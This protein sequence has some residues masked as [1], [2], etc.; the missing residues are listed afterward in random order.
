MLITTATQ[1]EFPHVIKSFF[2]FF[3]NE[4]FDFRKEENPSRGVKVNRFFTS[5]VNKQVNH[6]CLQVSLQ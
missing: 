6:L 5:H 1:L 4:M 3:P 2:F